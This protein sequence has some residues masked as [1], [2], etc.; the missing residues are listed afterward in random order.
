MSEILTPEEM[1]ALT[2]VTQAELQ[3]EQLCVQGVRFLINRRGRPVVIWES[4]RQAVLSNAAGD[5]APKF[6]ALSNV[7]KTARS[8]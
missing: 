3:K 2:G 6:E 7:T 8:R 4:V 1:E 5:A